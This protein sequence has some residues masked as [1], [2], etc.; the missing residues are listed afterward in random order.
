VPNQDCKDSCDAVVHAGGERARGH[1]AL[2][3][4]QAYVYAAW[5]A[6]SLMADALGM[7]DEAL[8][9]TARADELRKR[10]DEAFFDEELG[11]YVLALDGDK[12]PCRVRTSNAGHTLLTG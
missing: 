8:R 10:F 11:T 12:K 7:P 5:R 2:G 3:E 9:Y 4:L 1:I 6:A